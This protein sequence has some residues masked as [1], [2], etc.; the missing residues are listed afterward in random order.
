MGGRIWA[1][2][3]GLQ[4]QKILEWLDGHIYSEQNIV[5]D[6]N[7]EKRAMQKSDN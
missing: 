1:K 2:D 7:S 3:T 6:E 5:I 4:V